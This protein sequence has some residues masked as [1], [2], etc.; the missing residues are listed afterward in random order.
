MLNKNAKLSAKVFADDIEKAPTR[1]GFGKGT[2]EAGKADPRIVVLCA[3]LAESTRAE[4]FQKE[5][6][7]RFIEMGVAE[8][9]MATVAAGM[10][11]AGKIPFTASYAAFNPGRNYEQIRTTIALNNVSVKICGMHAGVSVGPDG[12]T[13]QMLEDIG[14]MRMLPNMIVLTP[15]DAEE[16]RKAVI[17][18]TATDGPV[19]IRFGRAATPVFTTPESPFRIG[20]A[21]LLWESENPKIAI[22]STGSLSHTA[23]VAARNL[24]EKGIETLVFH[25]PTVKP[26]DG[27]AVIDAAKRTGVVVTIE[28]HQVAG[29]FG[30]AV[31]EFLAEHHPMPLKRLGIQDQFGQSG[32]PEELLSHY[33]LDAMHI[34]EAVRAF[35]AK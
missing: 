27:E 6:P 21:L 10:A 5:F 8:Q 35:V 23:L 17:A 34:E 24:S 29:G 11:L 20:K 25:L 14:L 15:G 32:S 9:N 33:G 12:A 4:W 7:E 22:L 2:V 3:D 31:A 18:A 26:L 1:D 30:S 13:H 28:E 19:Y 16:A